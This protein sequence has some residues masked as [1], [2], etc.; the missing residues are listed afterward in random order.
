MSTKTISA[1]PKRPSDCTKRPRQTRRGRVRGRSHR[2]SR[3]RA[4]GPNSILNAPSR[5]SLI[6]ETAER[7]EGN[8]KSI[9]RQRSRHGGRLCA[10][11][12]AAFDVLAL[13]SLYSTFVCAKNTGGPEA[14]VAGELAETASEYVQMPQHLQRKPRTVFLAPQII[15][16]STA[17]VNGSCR[18]IASSILYIL[19]T[20]KSKVTLHVSSPPARQLLAVSHLSSQKRNDLIQRRDS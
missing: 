10:G 4:S 6:L 5:R 11:A 19:F 15:K 14:G 3:R 17:R 12:R 8:S 13:H 7:R 18:F 9:V 2:P 20:V 1:A 16:I